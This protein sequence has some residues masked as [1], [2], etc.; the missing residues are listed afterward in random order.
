MLCDSPHYTPPFNVCA[1]AKDLALLPAWYAE[2]GDYVLIDGPEHQPFSEWLPP[3]IQLRAVPVT[4]KEL[5]CKQ[6]SL[7]HMEAAPW[8]V[9]PQSI[10]LFEE[11]KQAHELDLYIPVWK[12]EYAALTSRRTA[13]ACLIRMQQML[14]DIDL[15]RPP[16]FF[17]QIEELEAYMHQHQAPFVLKAPYS[18]SGRGLIW[19]TGSP[20]NNSE[21]NRIRGLLR[22]QNVVSLEY[23]LNKVADF[24]LEF[25]SDGKGN[26]CEKG[27]S[28]FS[29][30]SRGAYT[31]NRLQ[32]QSAIRK[33]FIKYTGEHMSNVIQQSLAS[34]LCDTF[35]S[36][37]AGY[38]GVDM[39]VYKG[40]E[41]FGIHPCV[42]INLRYTMGMVAIR[43]FER[44]LAPGATGIFNISYENNP[45][46]VY[47][48]HL[49]MKKTCPPSFVNGRLQKGYL[50]LCPVTHETRYTAC[51]IAGT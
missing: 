30:N 2:E 1:L 36:K 24:A 9:S 29:T 4:R 3:E 13:T 6:S 8:G 35:G 27:I 15:P 10:R 38:L 40:S 18:S 23:A 11:L 19:L 48:Q 46:N 7:T 32:S 21:R 34:V 51:I 39:L 28:M 41:G 47:D 33:E 17:S 50:S 20:L 5:S 42:E 14:P 31:G 22:R 45:R 43:L 16:V 44:F 26:L 37:Y 49:H 25:Y 12:D